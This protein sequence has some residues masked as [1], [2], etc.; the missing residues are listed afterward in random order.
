MSQVGKIIDGKYE[1]LT[2]IGRGG[3]SVVYLA[4]DRR[5]N[6]QWAIKEVKRTSN[7]ENQEVVY[8]SLLTEAN[9]MKK[10]D[11][12]RL[13]RI[14]D[15]IESGNTLYV[16][17]DYIEGRPMDKVLKHNGPNKQE[18]IKAWE[19]QVVKWGIQICE[20]LD[21]LHTRTPAIIYRDM[22]P[23]NLMLK[24]DGTVNVFDF[25]I[26]REY[27]EGRKGD[28][29]I[30]GTRGYAA[31]ESF[32][33][34]GQTDARTDIYCLGV[35]LY[36]MLTGK[37]PTE[38]PYTLQPIR[39]CNPQLSDGMEWIIQKCTQPDPLARFQ[40]CEELM[41]YLKNVEGMDRSVIAR[42]KRK[43][44]SFLVPAMLTVVFLLVGIAGTIGSIQNKESAYRNY[45]AKGQYEEA[46]KKFPERLEPYKR[47]IDKCRE[48][49][50]FASD[51]EEKIG[52]YISVSN[53]NTTLQIE[54]TTVVKEGE[55]VIQ[56]GAM[57]PSYGYYNLLYEIGDLYWN[58]YDDKKQQIK[59]AFPYF[60]KIRNGGDLAEEQLGKEK[61]ALAEQY[62]AIGYYELHYDNGELEEKKTC[63]NGLYEI[64]EPLLESSVYDD[65]DYN[66]LRAKYC[67]LMNGFIVEHLKEHNKDVAPIPKKDMLNLSEN[68]KQA[69]ER[70]KKE[71]VDKSLGEDYQDIFEN[72]L[73]TKETREKQIDKAYDE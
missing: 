54:A 52:A 72:I 25:G 55:L 27:K 11:H 62:Y 29:T 7:G 9:L 51:E 23:S 39:Q 26:A 50:V 1:I 36:Q 58:D 37:D 15:I 40:S 64:N 60:E 31:P 12:P 18:D 67:Q 65:Q 49:G 42:Q 22:K 53:D 73:E 14:V 47:W 70:M 6:K 2:E 19:R 68:M 16:V 5:L 35:T 56:D 4:R 34:S 30:M 13:P 38:P 46:I 32:G 24:P 57:L 66:E 10:L 17:M 21:Y 43:L 45:I 59:E 3:M 63:W 28:T 8:Q 41:Y 69:C 61:F 20:V 33:G 48:D 44:V 71:G